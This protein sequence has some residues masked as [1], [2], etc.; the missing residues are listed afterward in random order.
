MSNQGQDEANCHIIHLQTTLN[1]P[2]Q[3]SPQK[4]RTSKDFMVIRD[5]DFH[6]YLPQQN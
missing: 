6:S 3:M 4:S 2:H 1:L 5:E